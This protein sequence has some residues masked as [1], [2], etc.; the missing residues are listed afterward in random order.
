MDF[1][2]LEEIRLGIKDNNPFAYMKEV[3]YFYGKCSFSPSFSQEEIVSEMLKTAESGNIYAMAEI[4]K[5]YD[6]G[7]YVEK[8]EEKYFQWLKKIIDSGNGSMTARTLFDE[9]NGYINAQ[10]NDYFDALIF[11]DPVGQAALQLGLKEMN[12]SKEK[13]L[14]TALQYFKIAC[15][16]HWDCE[17]YICDVENRLRELA[18]PKITKTP[19]LETTSRDFIANLSQK[20]IDDFGRVNWDKL[21]EVSQ[22]YI[23]TATFAFQQLLAIEEKSFSYIDFSIVVS[24]LL[25]ALELELKI[26]LYEQYLDYL[27]NTFHNVEDYLNYNNI[28]GF[29]EIKSRNI[30]ITKNAENVYCFE[31]QGSNKFTLGSLKYFFGINNTKTQGSRKTIIDKSAFDFLSIHLKKDNLS[32]PLWIENLCNDIETVRRLRNESS[33]GGTILSL[34]DAQYTINQL[35]KIKRI[36]INI[37]SD[38][39]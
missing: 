12:I 24:P 28:S 31:D 9:A 14:N 11:S 21:S 5:W 18:Q 17:K 4:A 23:N 35:I 16:C 36:L 32:P 27:K 19:T 26:R 39:Q 15:V 30:I 38:W 6:T 1:N 13:N 8:S 25:R 3:D 10:S 2:S 34:N 37:L 7:A 22:K 20:N 29:Y 33:H